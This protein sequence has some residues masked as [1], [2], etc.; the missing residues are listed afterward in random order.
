MCVFCERA[1]SGVN[2]LYQCDPDINRLA[3]TMML[4]SEQHSALYQSIDE[5]GIKTD[6][7][8]I[9]SINFLCIP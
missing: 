9:F 5:K 6:L 8:E 2:L 1:F 4:Y 3:C 7:L